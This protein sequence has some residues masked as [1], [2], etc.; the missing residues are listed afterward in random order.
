MKITIDIGGDFAEEVVRAALRQT[1]AM[2]EDEVRS[3]V[4]YGDRVDH[5]LN[6]EAAVRM[7]NYY[8]CPSEWYKPIGEQDE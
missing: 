3:A 7:H 8:A 1:V 6:L 5:V 2:L 4:V